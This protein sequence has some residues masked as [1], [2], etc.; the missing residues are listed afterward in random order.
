MELIEIESDDGILAFD[1]RVLE[2]FAAGSREAS[3]RVHARQVAR[4]ELEPRKGVVL[5]K[6]VKDAK[7]YGGFLAR[8]DDPRI[9]ELRLAVVRAS[10]RNG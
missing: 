10:G 4:V 8:E 1:G 7:W 2:F 5:I 6:A 3:W 9:E